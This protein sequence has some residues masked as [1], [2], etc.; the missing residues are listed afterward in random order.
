[1]AKAKKV[2]VDPNI[3]DYYALYNLTRGADS[4]TLVSQPRKKQGE[5]KQMMSCSATGSETIMETLL[6]QDKLVTAAIKIFK[7]KE[8]LEEYNAQ[9]DAAIAS[10]TLN[11]EAQEAAQSA[12]DEIE[13]LFLKGN[14]NAV[15]KMCRSAINEN[16]A[17]AKL[18]NFLAQSYYMVDQGESALAA[19]D[20]FVK[21]YPKD[22][23]ALDMGVRYNILIHNDMEKAQDYL[24]R[25]HEFYTDSALASIDQIYIHLA[26]RNTEMAFKEIDDFVSAN[27]ADQDFRKNIAYDMIGFC[28]KL[29]ACV[30]YEGD[31]I[32]FL[33]SDEDYQLCKAMADKAATVYHDPKVQGYVEYTNHMGEVEFN[34]DN[35]S[36]IRWTMFAAWIYGVAGVMALSSG[37]GPGS[38]IAILLAA[39]CA[40]V[41]V[42]LHKVSKR[43][44]WQIYK[45]EL[46]GQREPKEKRYITIGNIIAG[47][48]RWSVKLAFGMIRLIFSFI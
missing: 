33:T 45:Y 18:Y 1:M 38:F 10:G 5:I 3:I 32:A 8:K 22:A 17:N 2:K 28:S 41:T 34:Q 25:I 37:V 11:T 47:Y 27:P 26:Q 44:Y 36:N 16:G 23:E 4:K 6:E 13:R 42:M 29:Y 30:E 24:N 7:N 43:P 48:M 9:L 19:V 21:A 31:E 40:Y 35:K 14:Y 20:E 15:I 39:A 46:T 12:L